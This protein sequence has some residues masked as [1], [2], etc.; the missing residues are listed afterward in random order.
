MFGTA[1][2]RDNLGT[3]W[4]RDKVETAWERDMF[5]MHSVDYVDEGKWAP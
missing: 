2:E 5:G 1:W 3:T 4:D